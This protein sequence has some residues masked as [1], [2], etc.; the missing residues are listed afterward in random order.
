MNLPPPGNKNPGQ[1]LASGIDRSLKALPI[2]F[3]SRGGSWA[4]GS[5]TDSWSP[6]WGWEAV[7]RA[8][9]QT[10][11]FKGGLELWKM[12]EINTKMHLRRCHLY[13]FALRHIQNIPTILGRGSGCGEKAPHQDEN[14]ITD[15]EM[16]TI[17]TLCHG[18][19]KTFNLVYKIY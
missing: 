5:I 19:P 9:L 10:E 14:R 11:V 2:P 18:L 16:S 13:H 17:L 4:W 8:W 6:A 15:Y 1:E 7:W 3:L 12:N